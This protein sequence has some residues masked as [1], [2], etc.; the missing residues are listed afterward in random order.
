MTENYYEPVVV[1]DATETI[2]LFKDGIDY[3]RSQDTLAIPITT[4]KLEN[5]E[6]YTTF[7]NSFTLGLEPSKNGMPLGEGLQE[8]K[9][10]LRAEFMNSIFSSL[11]NGAYKECGITLDTDDAYGVLALLGSIDNAL[12]TAIKYDNMIVGP[13]LLAVI[14]SIP[15]MDNVYNYTT[16][17]LEEGTVRMLFGPQKVGTVV[18]QKGNSVSVA[19]TLPDGVRDYCAFDDG[20]IIIE[21]VDMREDSEPGMVTVS[22]VC[23]ART[24]WLDKMSSLANP[25]I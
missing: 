17:P 18:D 19:L 7:E 23:H 22:T 12:D 21:I 8:I 25:N 5:S 2:E 15:E 16:V 20:D 11:H 9:I 3:L 13:L 10:A 4:E 1:M 6:D 14:Q 24:V